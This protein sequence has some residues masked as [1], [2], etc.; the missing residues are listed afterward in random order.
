MPL[1][2]VNKVERKTPACREAAGGAARRSRLS[3]VVHRD[4]EGESGK[5]HHQIAW[6]NVLGR[7]N[8]QTQPWRVKNIQV[9][10][11]DDMGTAPCERVHAVN[12][13]YTNVVSKLL[14]VVRGKR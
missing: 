6:K 12:P 7:Q 5:I 11:L 1:V 14:C 3:W 13:W 10:L 9:A 4:V 8:D 2:Y